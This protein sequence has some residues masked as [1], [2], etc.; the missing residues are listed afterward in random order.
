MLYHLRI[1]LELFKLG[2]GI[3]SYE[4]WPTHV[5]FDIVLMT[6]KS[7]QHLGIYLNFPPLFTFNNINVSHCFIVQLFSRVLLRYN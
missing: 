4:L 7:S 5:I 6:D 2:L 1:L 3:T